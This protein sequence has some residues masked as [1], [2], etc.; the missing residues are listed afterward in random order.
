MLWTDEKVTVLKRLWPNP[1]WSAARI[2]KELRLSRNAVIGKAHRIGLSDKAI[3]QR[4]PSTKTPP[5]RP[6][7]PRRALPDQ[8]QPTKPR[9][10]TTTPHEP[11]SK[12]ALRRIFEEAW[13][14]TAAKAAT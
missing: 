2:A 10:A 5:R 8:P 9:P 11:S 6:R 13:R 14:N 1:Q 4:P 12:Q 3:W 7:K